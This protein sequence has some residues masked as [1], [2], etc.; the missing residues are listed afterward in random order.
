MHSSSRPRPI[1]HLVSFVRGGSWPWPKFLEFLLEIRPV[2]DKGSA[3]IFPGNLGLSGEHISG[4]GAGIGVLGQSA[5]VTRPSV[6]H[7]C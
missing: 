4:I 2:F 5:V 1:V 3:R 7:D 6:V